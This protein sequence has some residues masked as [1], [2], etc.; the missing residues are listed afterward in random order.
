MKLKSLVQKPENI[1]RF[2]RHLGEP[3]EPPP[4]CLGQSKRFVRVVGHCRDRSGRAFGAPVGLRWAP[5]GSGG[6]REALAK[7]LQGRASSSWHRLP[8]SRPR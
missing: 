4:L 2:L 8:P 3:T 1:A 6:L 5:V 7:S